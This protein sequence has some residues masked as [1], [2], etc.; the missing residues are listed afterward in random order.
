MLAL[1]TVTYF[2]YGAQIHAR[3]PP[4]ID[5]GLEESSSGQFKQRV[6]KQSFKESSLP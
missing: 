4:G 5:R 6:S 1:S 3:S 2:A